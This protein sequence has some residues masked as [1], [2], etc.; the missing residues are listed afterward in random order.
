MYSFIKVKALYVCYRSIALDGF[1]YEKMV[2]RHNRNLR[3]M[4]NAY[5]LML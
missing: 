2:V 3:Q 4:R 5:Y 1:L